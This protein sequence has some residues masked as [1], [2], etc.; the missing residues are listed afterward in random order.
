[1]TSPGGTP[2]G[3]GMPS[4]AVVLRRAATCSAVGAG[5]VLS[6]PTP[7][8]S[9]IVAAHIP[10]SRLISALYRSTG[11]TARSSSVQC[12]SAPRTISESG[13]SRLI[14]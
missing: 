14:A 13:M 11:A 1:M 10:V 8:A 5:S 3:H 7:P 9:M 2:S 4:T 6:S 12:P